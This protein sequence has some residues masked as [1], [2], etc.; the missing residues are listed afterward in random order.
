MSQTNT[1]LA[2]QM[3]IVLFGLRNT[4]KSSIMNRLFGKEVAIVSDTPGTTTDPVTRSMEIIT[5]GP[6]T[7]TDTAGLDDVGQI[8]ELRMEKTME[9]LSTSDLPV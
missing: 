1:P 8:G 7:F 6:V 5:L 3:R 9:A 2:E 4:G